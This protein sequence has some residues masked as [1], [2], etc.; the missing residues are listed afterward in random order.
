MLMRQTRSVLSK[1]VLSP[2]RIRTV[3][4][5]NGERMPMLVRVD[6]GMPEFDAFVYATTVYDRE[7]DPPPRSSRRFAV[8]SFF[9]HSPSFV[10][11]RFRKGLSPAASSMRTNSMSW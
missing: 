9:W 5:E 2:H 4:F 11:S 8:F 6:T 3:V 1:Y 10:R 7:V